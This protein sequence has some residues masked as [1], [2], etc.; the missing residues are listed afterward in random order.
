MPKSILLISVHTDSRSTIEILKQ[1]N[2]NKKMNRHIQIKLKSVVQ[3]LLGKV[4]TLDFIK[5]EKKFC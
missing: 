5:S 2:V 3:R 4:V 1:D